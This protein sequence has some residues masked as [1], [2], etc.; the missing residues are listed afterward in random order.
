MNVAHRSPIFLLTGSFNIRAK[1]SRFWR[2]VKFGIFVGLVWASG[3]ALAQLLDAQI[4]TQKTPQQSEIGYSSVNSA[5]VTGYLL[6]CFLLTF[7]WV[8]VEWRRNPMSTV[9]HQRSLWRGSHKRYLWTYCRGWIS[10]HS[11]PPRLFVALSTPQPLRRSLL[12]PP[13][14][15]LLVSRSPTPRFSLFIAAHVDLRVNLSCV[16]FEIRSDQTKII[17]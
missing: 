5:F 12:S 7:A 4:A 15:S 17:N 9:A 6:F 16:W 11:A 10:I 8:V 13:S 1:R 14:T 2:L 3:K